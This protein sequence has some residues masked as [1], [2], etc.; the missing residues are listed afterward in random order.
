[1]QS[2]KFFKVHPNIIVNLISAHIREEI[3]EDPYTLTSI[4]NDF[5]RELFSKA[6]SSRGLPIA[7]EQTGEFEAGIIPESAPIDSIPEDILVQEK[8]GVRLFQ[9]TLLKHGLQLPLWDTFTL[10]DYLNTTM[11]PRTFQEP[12]RYHYLT[13]PHFYRFITNTDYTAKLRE[14]MIRREQRE[15]EERMRREFEEQQQQLIL[16]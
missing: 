10:F 6:A 8:V 12:A 7:A 3:T 5:K 13:F 14:D 2:F 11:E 1:M 15:K 9:N 4:E 16:Q